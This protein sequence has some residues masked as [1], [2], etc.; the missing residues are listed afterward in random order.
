MRTNLDMQAVI[1]ILGTAMG[2]L[3]R[4]DRVSS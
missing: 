1:F 2:T 4:R 3:L